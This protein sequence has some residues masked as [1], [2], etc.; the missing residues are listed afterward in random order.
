M[1]APSFEPTPPAPATTRPEPSAA[2]GPAVTGGS[3][4]VSLP[5]VGL[6]L[7]VALAIGVAVG[8][9]VRLLAAPNTSAPNTSARNVAGPNAA[10]PDVARPVANRSTGD[11]AGGRAADAAVLEARRRAT[12]LA[13]TLVEVRDRVANRAISDRIG[14]ALDAAGWTTIDPTG[15]PFD[16]HVHRAVDREITDD[17]E[18]DRTVAATERVGYT[19]DLGAVVRLPEVVVFHHE[20]AGPDDARSV[21]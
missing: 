18:L 3:D 8:Y 14:S 10:A 1:F 16:P 6:G 15:E 11:P 7:L 17:A 20:A 5:V 2:V 19:D 21:R 13:D 4:G 12:L 9:V